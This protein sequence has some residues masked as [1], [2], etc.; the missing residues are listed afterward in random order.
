[1]LSHIEEDEMA[2]KEVLGSVT[3]LLPQPQNAGSVAEFLDPSKGNFASA[4][5]HRYEKL[6]G[7][8]R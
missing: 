5:T 1:M 3:S 8:R 2:G 7:C 4:S 6:S